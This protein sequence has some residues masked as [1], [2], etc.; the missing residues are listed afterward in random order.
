MTP[1][2]PPGGSQI[3][4][5]LLARPQARRRARAAVLSR[6][7]AK[8]GAPS[9]QRGPDDVRSL[10]APVAGSERPSATALIRPGRRGGGQLPRKGYGRTEGLTVRGRLSPL[11]PDCQNGSL[12]PAVDG[13]VRTTIPCRRCPKGSETA[14]DERWWRQ[15]LVQRE[16]EGDG[17]PRGMCHAF[18]PCAVKAGMSSRYAPIA[19]IHARREASAA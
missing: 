1:D 3:T 7:P 2:P 10:T 6:R 5:A 4:N 16:V 19:P 18:L 17:R 14:A 8:T 12:S 11:R 15:L 13:A 9:A